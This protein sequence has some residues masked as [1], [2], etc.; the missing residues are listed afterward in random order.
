MLAASF[1]V[2]IRTETGATG[3][4]ALDWNKAA[5]A[6]RAQRNLFQPEGALV[7]A[8][9]M[10]CPGTEKVSMRRIVRKLPHGS[11]RRLGM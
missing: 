5:E 6:R 10:R 2:G 8:S 9:S 4:L 7:Q 11:N 3:V 1:F